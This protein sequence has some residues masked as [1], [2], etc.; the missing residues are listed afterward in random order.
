[1]AHK[2]RPVESGNGGSAV[3]QD[4]IKPI[5]AFGIVAFV[6]VTASDFDSTAP[7]AV[8]FAGVILLSTALLVGPVAFD[9][10]SKLVV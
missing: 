8:A 5:V 6:L 3:P 9:R 4:N 7:L 10:V 1:V 2:V